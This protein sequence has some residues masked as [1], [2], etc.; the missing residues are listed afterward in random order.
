MKAPQSINVWLVSEHDLL[1]WFPQFEKEKNR[2]IAFANMAKAV[3]DSDL[4][5]GSVVLELQTYSPHAAFR[6]RSTTGQ[7]LEH[8]KSVVMEMIA[9]EHNNFVPP[10]P[11]TPSEENKLEPVVLNM[12]FADDGE[13]WGKM[14]E[15]IEVWGKVS[16]DIT[17]V[18][19][20]ADEE[21]EDE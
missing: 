8:F 12:A 21:Y 6:L 3:A 7:S 19:E 5:H 17:E 9:Q 10:M 4:F 1:E 20:I 14:P 11:K 16:E 15:D 13:V 18:E 2:R